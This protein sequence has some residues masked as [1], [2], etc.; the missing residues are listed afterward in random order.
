MSFNKSTSKI[1]CGDIDLHT[2]DKTFIFWLKPNSFGESNGGRLIDNGKQ[3]IYTRSTSST[4][5]I[6]TNST[7]KLAA[8]NS[9]TFGK[10]IHLAV[11]MTNTGI[12]N[13]YVN[14]V[15][16]GTANQDAGVPVDGTSNLIIG[17]NNGQTTTFDGLINDARI[18]DG[19]LT[20]AEISQL[21]TS[22]KENYK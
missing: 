14:G 17:N 16:S 18:V 7:L 19:L 6:F 5:A 20:P 8:A 22:E 10:W 11:T 12:I 21:Y 2:S 1:D 3:I 15:L 4:F 9:V 13:F